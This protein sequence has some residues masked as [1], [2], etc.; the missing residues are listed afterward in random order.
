MLDRPR[1]RRSKGRCA[2]AG[3]AGG[4]GRG[5][6]RPTTFRGFVGGHAVTLDPPGL[7]D[8]RARALRGHAAMRPPTPHGLLGQAAWSSVR[9]GQKADFLDAFDNSIAVDDFMAAWWP[10]LDPREVLLWLADTDLAYRL[11]RGGLTDDE[12]AAIALSMREA[13]E[14]GTWTVAD[15][16]LIDD[17]A[18]RL[19]P[20]Q[21]SV[22]E[23]RG[24]YEIDALDTV[25]AGISFVRSDL[26]VP[27]A[28][29][30][31][32]IG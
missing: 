11:G 22:D 14:L 19:G 28:W 32:A 16:A 10:Q 12:C 9:M 24:F 6:G 21:E 27:C 3:L 23:D 18:A 20:V 30:P 13:L 4:H 5:A 8:V 15:V 26:G 17:Q 2:S 29:P 31:S 7:G 1:W 25:S